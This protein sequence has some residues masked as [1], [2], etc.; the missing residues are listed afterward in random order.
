MALPMNVAPKKTENGTRK[1]PHRKPARSNKGFGIEA[2]S[3]MVM[4]AFF[5]KV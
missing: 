2:R 5:Y 1:C 3:M 4:N